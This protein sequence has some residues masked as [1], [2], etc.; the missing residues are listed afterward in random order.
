MKKIN[1]YG[2]ESN[3]FIVGIHETKEQFIKEAQKLEN[4][5]IDSDYVYKGYLYGEID[6]KDSYFSKKE[7]PENI[8][9][10]GKQSECFYVEEDDIEEAEGE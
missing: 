9:K 10:Y 7:K 4:C 6:S 5:K 3:Y 1:R 8:K 2:D